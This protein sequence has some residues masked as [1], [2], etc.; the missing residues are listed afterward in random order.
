VPEETTRPDDDALVESSR[1][2]DP[3]AL[4]ILYERHAGALFRYLLHRSSDRVIAE[5]VVQES[6]LR[7]LERRG[8]YEGKGRFRSWLF[9]VGTRLAQDRERTR[10]RRGEIRDAFPHDLIPRPEGDPLERVRRHEILAAIDAALADLPV[11][12]AETFQLR[13]CEGF[14]Y[15]EIGEMLGEPEGTLR[16]RVHHALRRVRAHLASETSGTTSGQRTGGVRDAREGE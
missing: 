12:Y 6:F 14:S 3:R 1:E 9:T 7:I 15:R 11:T 4:A 16:S 8:R 10:R 2:G 5:D 13:I